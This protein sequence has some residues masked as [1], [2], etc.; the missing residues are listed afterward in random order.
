MIYHSEFPE[1]GKQNGAEIDSAGKTKSF[2]KK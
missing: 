1:R 2:A